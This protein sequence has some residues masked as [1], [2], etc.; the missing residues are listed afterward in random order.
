MNIQM[1]LNRKCFHAGVTI[2]SI[3]LCCTMTNALGEPLDVEPGLW[4][5]TVH[6]QGYGQLPFPKEAISDLSQEQRAA[7]I[8][9][10]EAGAR[11]VPR[12]HI[13]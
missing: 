5:M 10:I 4:E 13:R 8:A 9:K 6:T 1:T 12:H 11:H 3:S 2:T 7:I